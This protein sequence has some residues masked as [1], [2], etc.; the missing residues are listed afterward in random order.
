M[1][2]SGNLNCVSIAKVSYGEL[3]SRTLAL[4]VYDYDRS[5][6]DYMIGQVF[7]PLSHADVTH[8]QLEWRD[9]KSTSD[10]DQVDQ[11][12]SPFTISVLF[13]MI[14]SSSSVSSR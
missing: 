4:Q 5:S 11:R 13:L 8:V 2:E 14:F 7:Y 10:V 6:A 3:G 12:L 1:G 9:L